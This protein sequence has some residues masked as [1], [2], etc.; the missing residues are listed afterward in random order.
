[1]RL[2][3]LIVAGILLLIPQSCT[4]DGSRTPGEEPSFAGSPEI[5]Y[6]T[7]R[8]AEGYGRDMKSGKISYRANQALNAI[9]RLAA[10]KLNRIG[11]HKEARKLIYEWENQ[12]S[13]EIIRLSESRGI[14][15][16]KPLSS[17]LAEQC[18][19][20]RFL[21]GREAFYNLR[22]SDISTINFAIP[23]IIKCID[24]VTEQ[25]FFLHFVKDEENKYRGLGPVLGFWGSFFSCV[26]FSWGALFAACAPI[27]LGIEYLLETS[28][29]PQLNP[30]IWKISCKPKEVY[31]ARLAY[32]SSCNS[33]Y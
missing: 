30:Y 28:V 8:M 20:I 18:S 13:E 2:T 4:A 27:S 14:S 24:N 32:Q 22:I 1:M 3:N 15:D 23:V 5:S 31:H 17:W 29:C 26:G 16:H 7:R 9:I 21:I 10:Y 25:E 12:W 33:C 19:N 6:R 11:Y